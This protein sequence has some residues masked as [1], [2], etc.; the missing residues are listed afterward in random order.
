[1]VRQIRQVGQIEMNT[2]VAKAFTWSAVVLIIGL[3]VAQ[4]FLMHFIPSIAPHSSAEQ[5]RDRF[6]DR[7]NEIRVG[8]VI[9]IIAWSFWATWGV[10]VTTFMRRMERGYPFLTYASI[11]LVGGGSVVTPSG[12]SDDVSAA[13]TACG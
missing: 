10:V 6:L 5:V 7:K 9:Q 1:M 11:A 12:K 3:I 13:G 2:A 8:A 4:G